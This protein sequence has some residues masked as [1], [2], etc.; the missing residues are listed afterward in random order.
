[1]HNILQCVP[2][3]LVWRLVRSVKLDGLLSDFTVC[4]HNATDYIRTLLCTL[5]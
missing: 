3:P 1:M 5:F 2:V 4:N